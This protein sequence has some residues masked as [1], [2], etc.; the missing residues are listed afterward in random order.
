MG[1]EW[2][3]ACV[4]CRQWVWLG[5]MKPWKWSGFQMGSAFVAEML[6]LHATPSCTLIVT[7]DARAFEPPWQHDDAEC[8]W[9][10]DLRSRWFWD[11]I[12]HDATP[13]QMVCAT[14]EAPLELSTGAD[15]EA[16]RQEG[17]R[18]P[19]G[20]PTPLIVGRYLWF[21]GPACRD[22]HRSGPGRAWRA[23]P[24]A[25]PHARIRVGCRHCGVESSLGAREPDESDA[26]AFAEWLVDHVYDPPAPLG[27]DA[28]GCCRL[29]AHVEAA[30]ETPEPNARV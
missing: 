22:R 10:E 17:Y 30:A 19:G 26:L 5:S 8:G 28:P 25:S 4:T 12:R 1:V 21:C 2:D 7:S 29:E 13:P 23:H 15:V 18:S 11:S 6:S 9:L 24:D 27:L 20:A 3:L 14:C 16:L